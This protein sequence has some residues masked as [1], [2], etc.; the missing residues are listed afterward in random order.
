MDEN[1]KIPISIPA[2]LNKYSSIAAG[3]LKIEFITQEN[4]SPELLT[5]IISKKDKLGYLFFGV[6][7]IEAVDL[8]D[9]PKIDK[10]KYVNAKTDSQRQRNVLWLL[11]VQENKAL[12][13]TETD[14]NIINKKFEEF[15]HL[16]M[17]QII[18]WVKDKLE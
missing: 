13:E 14:K 4:I 15:Y 5:A 17:E 3:G 2:Y 11:F 6:K 10:T 7:Q 8:L 1:R 12:M 9:L 18:N 16:K